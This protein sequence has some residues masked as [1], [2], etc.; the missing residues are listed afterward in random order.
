MEG[1][2]FPDFC[3]RG[4]FAAAMTPQERALLFLLMDL[5]SCV[6]DESKPPAPPPIK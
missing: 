1:Q 6:Q 2:T 5:A 4:Q 3:K